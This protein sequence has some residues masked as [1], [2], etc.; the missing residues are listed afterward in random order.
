MPTV[1]YGTEGGQ[2]DDRVK[3]SSFFRTTASNRDYEEIYLSI[4]QQIGWKRVA[5]ITEDGSTSAEYMA[6]VETRLSSNGIKIVAS[7][8]LPKKELN[9]NNVEVTLQS[10]C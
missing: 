9:D 7:K 5:T 1:S 2:Y 4:F 3:Y 10:V 6:H 8:R